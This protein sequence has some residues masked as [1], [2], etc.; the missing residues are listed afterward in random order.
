M[1][2]YSNRFLLILFFLKQILT[3]ASTGYNFLNI[4][5]N[6]LILFPTSLKFNLVYF[7]IYLKKFQTIFCAVLEMCVNSNLFKIGF[8]RERRK[9]SKVLG[10]TSPPH[11][12]KASILNPGI[13]FLVCSLT[14]L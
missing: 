3:T 9:L 5:P 2:V 6:E 4:T 14:R 11:N 7:K 13:I 12:L 10:C 1:Y 8:W